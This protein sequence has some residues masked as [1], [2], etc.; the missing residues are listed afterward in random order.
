M[1][2]ILVLTFLTATE[3]KATLTI[4]NVKSDITETQISDLMDTIVANN[5]FEHKK[6]GFYTNKVSAELTSRTVTDYSFS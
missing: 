5:V 1:E 3:K 6:Y 2:Y 4:N